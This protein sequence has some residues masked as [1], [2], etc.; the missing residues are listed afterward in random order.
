MLLSG[1]P[2]SVAAQTSLNSAAMKN[3]FALDLQSLSPH[4]RPRWLRWQT[5]VTTFSSCSR[6]PGQVTAMPLSLPAQV[7]FPSVELAVRLN[8]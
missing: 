1:T 3:V 8:V 7:T 2:A 4:S 5:N 6:L